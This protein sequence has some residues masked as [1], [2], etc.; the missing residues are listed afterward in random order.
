MRDWHLPPRIGYALFSV[1]HVAPDLLAELRQI[2]LARAMVRG[3]PPRRVPGPVEA[4]SLMVPLLAYAIRRATRAAIAMEARGLEPGRRRT[5][6]DAQRFGRGD[7]AFV[8]VAFALLAA[9]LLSLPA[10]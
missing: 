10:G 6:L 4:A 9:V 7:A 3:A 2:R 5:I 1:L 8:A